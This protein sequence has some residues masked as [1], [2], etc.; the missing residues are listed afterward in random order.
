MKTYKYLSDSVVAKFDN[1]GISRMSCSVENEEFKAW[2]AEGNTP[3]PAD[4]LPIVSIVISPRQIRQALTQLN[5]REIV[6]SA[7]A[8]GDQDLKD[9]WEFATQIEENHPEVL[10]MATSLNI[11]EEQ[12]HELFVLAKSK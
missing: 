4:P 1:D 10:G 12:V 2:L 3:E 8:T 11:T 7:V 5:L 6:E 9:W